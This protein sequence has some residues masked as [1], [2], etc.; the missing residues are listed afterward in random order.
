MTAEQHREEA[1]RCS[2]PGFT[3]RPVPWLV[4]RAAQ[5]RA[6]AAHHE[7]AAARGRAVRTEPR[8]PR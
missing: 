3:G 1:Q 8:R 7:R 2:R 5:Q 6:L 4:E